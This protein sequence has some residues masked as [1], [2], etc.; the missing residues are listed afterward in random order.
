MAGSNLLQLSIDILNLM[1][2]S[3][4]FSLYYRNMYNLGQNSH[5]FIY[6]QVPLQ[7][8]LEQNYALRTNVYSD[9]F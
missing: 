5:P 2:Q 6:V 1:N 3:N 4:G 9:Q 7:K 8:I